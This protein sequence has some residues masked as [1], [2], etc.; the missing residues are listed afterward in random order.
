MES[1]D[2]CTEYL[3]FIKLNKRS[4]KATA[5]TKRV[6]SM[7]PDNKESRADA[8]PVTSGGWAR[9]HKFAAKYMMG[10]SIAPI[11]PMTAAIFFC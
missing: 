6:N 8:G 3:R 5:D 9:S 7:L 1:S 11:M 10:V 4:E 2:L